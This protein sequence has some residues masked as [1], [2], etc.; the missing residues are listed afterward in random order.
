MMMAFAQDYTTNSDDHSNHKILK[1]LGGGTCPPPYSAVPAYNLFDQPSVA[2]QIYVIRIQAKFLV[3][4]NG[5]AQ[6][7]YIWAA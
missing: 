5:L 6:V 4:K 3:E 7:E 1:L 2:T